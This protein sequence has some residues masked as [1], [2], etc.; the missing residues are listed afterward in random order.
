MR[1]SKVYPDEVRD[2]IFEN[3]KGT[4]VNEMVKAVNEKFGLE[5]SYEQIRGLYR[6][7]KLVSGTR[8]NNSGC[9]KKGNAPHNTLPVGSVIKDTYGYWKRKVCDNPHE[10]VF[11]HREIWEEANGPIPKNSIVIFKD[12][13]KDNYQLDNLMCITQRE[14]QILNKKKLRSSDGE[15]TETAVLLARL[16]AAKNDK[17]RGDRK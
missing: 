3:Y 1:K 14:N 13:N 6:R 10:W 2:F 17:M 9:Y 5:Y 11:L 15:V 8:G 7:N 16:I 4:A 12:G